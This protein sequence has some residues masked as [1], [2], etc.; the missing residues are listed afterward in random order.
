MIVE[1]SGLYLTRTARRVGITGP[2]PGCAQRFRWVTTAGYYV[3][4]D[5]RASLAGGVTSL[6][7]CARVDQARPPSQ[8][9]L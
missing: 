7:L 9:L 6:D 5:G 1:P 4:A 3:T 2:A 8:S